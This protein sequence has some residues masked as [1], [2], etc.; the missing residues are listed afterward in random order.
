MR[1][2]D[3]TKQVDK[4]KRKHGKYDTENEKIKT[5]WIRYKR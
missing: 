3:H 4:I 5:T 2:E 1:K